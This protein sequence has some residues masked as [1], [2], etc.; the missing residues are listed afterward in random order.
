MQVVFLKMTNEEYQQFVKRHAPK[1]PVLGD[2]VKAFL[3]GGLICCGGQALTE[4]YSKLAGMETDAAAAWV[5]I[6]LV[7]L[8]ALLTGLNVYDKLARFAGAGTLVPITGFANALS[9]S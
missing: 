5:S 6:T 3:V 4:A 1:S 7:L 2:V 8:S 9:P